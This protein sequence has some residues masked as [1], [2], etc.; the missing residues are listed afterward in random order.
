MASTLRT[1]GLSPLLGL[2]V[3]RGK[4]EGILCS[5][6]WGPRRA[7]GRGFPRLARAERRLLLAGS[8]GTRQG[9]YVPSPGLPLQVQGAPGTS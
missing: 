9:G 2:G 4:Q 1:G 5:E 3:W 8:A 7:G 6:L